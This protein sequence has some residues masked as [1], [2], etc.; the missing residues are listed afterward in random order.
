MADEH[1]DLLIIGAGLSGVGTG[2][3][4]AKTFPRKSYVILEQREELGGTWSLF[5]YPGIRSDS[6]MHTLG[7]RFKPWTAA[8]AIADGPAILDYVRETAREGDVERHIRYRTK[9]ERAEWDTATA[10]WTVEARNVA[11]D[12]VTTYTCRYL[13]C[14]AGYYDYDNGYRPDFPGEERFTGPIIHPQF[15]PEDLDYTG[16]RVV[17][18]GSGAT[19]ITIVPAMAQTAEHVTMLQRSPTYIVSLPG[20]DALANRLRK[21]LPASWAYGIVRWKNVLRVLFSFQMS[22][23]KPEWVRWVL[24]KALEKNEGLS[25]AEIDANFTPTYNPWQQRL[26]AVPDGDFFQAMRD[27]K[28]SVVTDHIETFTE[29]GIRLKS[30]EEL[31]AD[32]VVTA[33]GLSLIPFG[34]VELVVDGEKIDVANTVTYKGI[35]LSGVPNYAIAFGYTNSSWTLK[36][37]LT[38][39]YMWRLIKHIERRGLRQFMPRHNPPVSDTPYID[40]NSGYVLRALDKMPKQGIEQPW[41]LSMNYAIDFFELRYTKVD[42]GEMQFSNPASRSTKTT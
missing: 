29:T 38:Y 16:K 28:V 6:D 25:P 37:D 10:L 8:K 27:G 11:T 33:T 30:G 42:D 26:C 31:P 17:V 1:V 3:Q 23:R 40:F 5:K 35:M 14:C 36:V 15:W 4:F 22:R 12:E 13:F 41:R 7:Y 20:E 18:V 39:A 34:G 9:V 2:Y 21:H 24:R 32:I 19:A